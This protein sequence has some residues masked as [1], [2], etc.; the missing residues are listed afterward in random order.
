MDRVVDLFEASGVSFEEFLD[1][2]KIVN[3]IKDDQ[4]KIKNQQPKHQEIDNEPYHLMARLQICTI[5]GE[6]PGPFFGSAGLTNQL[7][8]QS[9]SLAHFRSADDLSGNL[10]A[11]PGFFKRG[12]G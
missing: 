6:H 11:T 9:P 2:L 4:R 12:L 7:A 10:R 3:G 5:D 1:G 8:F